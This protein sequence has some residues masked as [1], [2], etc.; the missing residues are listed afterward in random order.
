MKYTTLGGSGIAVSRLC[1]GTMLFGGDGPA[2]VDADGARRIIDAFLDGGG[3]YFDTANVYAGGRSEEVLG[4]TLRGR[5]DSIVL[6]TK[7]GAQR[8]DDPLHPRAGLTRTAVLAEIDDSLRRLGTDYIDLWYLH[9]PDRL[10]AIEETWTAVEA[11]W[12]A[13]KIRAVGLSNFPAWVAA[14]ATLKAPMPV[15]AAQYQYSLICREI[16]D[17]YFDGLRR[18]GMV[19][20]AWAPLAQGFLTGKYRPGGSPDAGRIATAAES[21]EEHWS[22][23]DR[24]SNWTI[25]EAVQAIADRRDA[26]PGQVAIA[27]TLHRPVQAVAVIG[28]RT[29][30]QLAESLGAADLMLGDEDLALLEEVSRPPRRYPFRVIDNY[31]DRRVG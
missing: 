15:V 9:G 8:G 29:D 12:R 19:L 25:L 21:H 14:E 11:A 1:L 22:R 7:A 27:W 23:R 31:F 20:H 6:A 18:H 10:T 4:A 24:E 28:A 26:T 5:R 13:G 2:D 30:S 3:T 17:D 16:E